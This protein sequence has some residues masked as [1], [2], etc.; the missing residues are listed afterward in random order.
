MDFYEIRFIETSK[1]CNRDVNP[2][3]I[4]AM[5]VFFSLKR[6]FTESTICAE[7]ESKISNDCGLESLACLTQTFSIQYSISFSFIHPVELAR[8]ITSDGKF[9]FEFK[10]YKRRKFS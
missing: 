6:L 8:I 2:P 5:L 3:G 1:G 4:T 9:P 7:K 10:D